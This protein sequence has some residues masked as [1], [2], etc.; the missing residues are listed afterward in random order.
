M[1]IGVGREH[2]TP[3]V[4]LDE[5]ERFARRSIVCVHH[6]KR[7]IDLQCNCHNCDNIDFEVNSVGLLSESPRNFQK[8]LTAARAV[9]TLQILSEPELGFLN[10][11]QQLRRLFGQLQRMQFSIVPTAFHSYNKWYFFSV[12]FLLLHA[13]EHLCFTYVPRMRTCVLM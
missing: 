8:I 4:I 3:N 1:C 7:Q 9:R 13:R 6:C 5:A 2:V 10:F 12:P 11:C